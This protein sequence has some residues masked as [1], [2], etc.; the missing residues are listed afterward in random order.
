MSDFRGWGQ[1]EKT[2]QGLF[3]KPSLTGLL[4]S[5]AHGVM[6][7]FV[8]KILGSYSGTVVEVLRGAVTGSRRATSAVQGAEDRLSNGVLQTDVLEDVRFLVCAWENVIL[9]Y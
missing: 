1:D 7:A 6:E 4:H 2:P 9:G 8:V 3:P 5:M